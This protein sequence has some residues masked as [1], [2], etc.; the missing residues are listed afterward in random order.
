MRHLKGISF[1]VCLVCLGS[2]VFLRS[3]GPASLARAASA[4]GLPQ[5]AAKAGCEDRDRDGYGRGCSLGPDCNDQDV[6]V[7]PGQAERC[8]FR[9]DDCN[10]EVDDAPD[11][12]VLSES[13]G[14]IFVKAGEFVMGSPPGEGANDEQPRHRVWVSDYSL[15]KFEVTNG[16]YRACVRAGAC[17]PPQLPSSRLRPDYFDNAHYSDFPVVFVDAKRAEI[18]CRFRG[19]RLPTEA[20]WEKAARGS[21]PSLAR[22]PWGDREPDCSL[23]NLGGPQSCLGDTDRVGRR[24]AGQSPTGALDMAGNVWEWV[25]DYYDASYY[26]YSP[27]RDP[28]G[29]DSGSLRTIR[30]GCFESG[31]DSLRVSCRKPMVVSTW[32][33]NIGFRCAYGKE[34]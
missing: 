17:E 22:F 20:Q 26:G 18:Y 27:K 8:N 33:Y 11:C 34:G 24:I 2:L 16:R 25:A 1:G 7:H 13:D 4:T 3:H 5:S 32:A 23:A 15:D 9:D 28:M 14:R 19:G 6:L 10:G 30:G 31:A 12:P 21:S 29:P